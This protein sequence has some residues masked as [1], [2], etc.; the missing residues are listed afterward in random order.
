[1][2]CGRLVFHVKQDPLYQVHVLCCSKGG[3]T[4]P[5]HSSERGYCTIFTK[6]VPL[7]FPHPAKYDLDGLALP[8]NIHR[9]IQKSQMNLVRAA[10]E[11]GYAALCRNSLWFNFFLKAGPPP[12]I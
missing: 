6:Y 2:T 11:Y 4:F 1:M 3:K 9:N 5:P 8:G 10:E 7:I 12:N